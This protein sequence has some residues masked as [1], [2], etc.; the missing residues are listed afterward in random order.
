MLSVGQYGP[1]DHYCYACYAGKVCFRL[2]S[3]HSHKVLDGCLERCSC[4]L[5]CMLA[6][7][8]LNEGAYMQM[9][10]RIR[11]E[12]NPSGEFGELIEDAA[13]HNPLPHLLQG[14]SRLNAYTANQTT[15]NVTYRYARGSKGQARTAG[16]LQA[17]NKT[18]GSGVARRTKSE[19]I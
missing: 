1:R 16:T 3:G 8:H 5:S 9:H 19:I 18:R 6:G 14:R 10:R 11:Q 2:C 15:T 4:L 12:L 17:R 13:L 7:C